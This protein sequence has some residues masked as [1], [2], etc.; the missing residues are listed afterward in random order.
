MSITKLPVNYQDGV[1]D[2]TR[3]YVMAENQDHTFSFTDVS[4]FIR[5]EL[6][7]SAEEFNNVNETINELVDLAEENNARIDDLIDDIGDI[8]AGEVSVPRATHAETAGTAPNASSATSA[9][10]ATRAGTATYATSATSAN[11]AVS[12][13][14]I[15]SEFILYN[16]V[17]LT[18]INKQC[19]ISDNRITVNSLANMYFADTTSK[20]NAKNADLTI[21]PQAGRLLIT[22]VKNPSPITVSIKVKVV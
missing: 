1:I 13:P 11:S 18:F 8:L 2:G 5:E 4:D 10:H 22:A 6:L 12:V 20:A 15:A 16:N 17:Q 19:V 21:I 3:K 9:D 14:I 7:I